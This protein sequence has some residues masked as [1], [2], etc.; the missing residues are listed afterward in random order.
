MPKIVDESTIYRAAIQVFVSRGYEGATTREIAALAEVNEATLFRRYGTKSSL[1]A[2]AIDHR[3][4]DTPLNHLTYSGDLESDITAIVEAYVE[5][6]QIHGDVV[7]ILIQEVPRHSDLRSAS[8]VLLRNLQPALGLFRRYQA[9]GKLNPEAPLAALISL[10]GSVMLLL[11]LRRSGLGLGIPEL[12]AP[13]YA[14]AYL[15]GR[16]IE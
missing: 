16:A 14:K 4:S 13:T 12:D 5:T 15:N 10:I 8:E 11:T 1:Y 7:A 9:E 6:Y 3:L 2:K